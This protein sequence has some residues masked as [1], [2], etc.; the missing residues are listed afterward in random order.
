MLLA[1]LDQRRLPPSAR[2]SK[3]AVAMLLAAI[4]K[5]LPAGRQ[6]AKV[7]GTVSIVFVGEAEIRRVN[8]AYRKKDKVTDVLAFEAPLMEVLICYPQAR[9]QAKERGHT[10][11]EEVMDLIIHG[12]LHTFGF[13]HERQRDAK[14]MLPLQKKIYER[15]THR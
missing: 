14:V 1:E 7:S 6:G 2:V 12:V 10:V 9:R 3:R 15:L 5:F 11:K 4:E 13:D 8:R